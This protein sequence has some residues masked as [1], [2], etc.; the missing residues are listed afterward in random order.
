MAY[1]EE[2]GSISGFKGCRSVEDFREANKELFESEVDVLIPA[3]LESQITERNASKIR[4]KIVVEG[5][6]GPTTFKAD[7]ILDG[8][9][10]FVI[11][12]ILA[13]S[14]GV[15]VSYFEWVQDVQAYFWTEDEVNSRLKQVILNA[16]KEV[17]DNAEKYKVDMRDAAYMLALQRV[18]EGLKLRGIFP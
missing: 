8:N 3:A 2:K 6:N 1:N 17:S 13:N 16:Y 9:G 4:A 11:P 14:G 15:I 7:D 10:V 18:S 5:A 12:D